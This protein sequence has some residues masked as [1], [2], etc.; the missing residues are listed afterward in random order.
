LNSL[1]GTFQD[2]TLNRRQR[3]R[4]V[5]STK[6]LPPTEWAAF[7]RRHGGPLW[8]ALAI[9]PYVRLIAGRRR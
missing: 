2:T 9:S 7:C 3:F 1:E 4:H 6:G 8:P 5:A